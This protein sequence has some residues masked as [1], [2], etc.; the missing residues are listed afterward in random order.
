M[1]TFIG[2]WSIK[3][4]FSTE[5]TSIVP[6]VLC[7]VDT[8]SLKLRS[9][10]LFTLAWQEAWS[11]DQSTGELKVLHCNFPKERYKE[12]PPITLNQF[13]NGPIIPAHKQS[14]PSCARDMLLVM[15][16]SLYHIEK[17]IILS[18]VS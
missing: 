16:S 8:E 7:P 9:Y 13:E 5:E 15:I 3:C 4:L 11:F 17:C 2:Y 14:F 10:T 12:K 18:S 1:V 6:M